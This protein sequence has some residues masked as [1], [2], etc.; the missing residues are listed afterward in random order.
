MMHALRD[1]WRRDYEELRS[2]IQETREHL[3]RREREQDEHR[4]RIEQLMRQVLRKQ[5]HHE[6]QSVLK[7][8]AA[9]N[10]SASG[11]ATSGDDLRPSETIQGQRGASA[12]GKECIPSSG[13]SE[14]SKALEE[15]RENGIAPPSESW[16]QNNPAAATWGYSDIHGHKG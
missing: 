8:Q 2:D 9:A 1:S 11:A 16:A 15:H 5:Q 12:S 14:K 6:E 4:L 3:S 7:R 10:A 13:E